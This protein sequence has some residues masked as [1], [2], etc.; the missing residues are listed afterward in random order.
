MAEGAVGG[1]DG[2][3]TNEGTDAW[4]EGR[5]AGLTFHKLAVALRPAG[6]KGHWRSPSHE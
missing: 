5:S 6:K 3:Y 4:E 2:H 1:K